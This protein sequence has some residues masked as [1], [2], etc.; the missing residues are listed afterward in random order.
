M[1]KREGIIIY[2]I[3]SL[4][5][6]A[7]KIL[8]VP[9]VFLH[10]LFK[11]LEEIEIKQSLSDNGQYVEFCHLA[12]WNT[13]A[14]DTFRSNPIYN[15]I[16]EHVSYEQG[17]E[18]LKKIPTKERFE[19]FKKNDLYGG[20][21]RCHYIE[22]GDISPTTL[23]YIKVLYDINKLFGNLAKKKIYEI[24]VG[25]GGQC[26][27]LCSYFKNIDEYVLLDL[28]PV[29]D[30]AKRYLNFYP[31][32]TQLKFRT[33]NECSCDE[34][35]DLVISNYAFTEISRDLQEVYMKK[36]I[37]KSK[38]GYI[39]YNE[40]TPPE[41]NSYTKKELLATMP[42]SV[43]YPEEPLTHPKNCIIAWNNVNPSR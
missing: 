35:V 16:L 39:T 38:C 17:L 34:S 12:S 9:I 20:A 30:L 6:I 18:Y 3:I 4:K 19:E 27:L 33:L 11:H 1:L 13:E 41:F 36:I 25:Y 23:R 42:N 26:R 37:K 5:K 8:R 32:S 40:I 15:V 28:P 22:V 21:R 10:R 2:F 43:E 31:I 29:L 24:G 14:F 7:K